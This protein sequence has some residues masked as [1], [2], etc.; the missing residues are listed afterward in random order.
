MTTGLDFRKVTAK[1]II[2]NSSTI[3]KM[4]SGVLNGKSVVETM[5]SLKVFSSFGADKLYSWHLKPLF[6]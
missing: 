5:L 4:T 2:K 6:A 1:N 3:T